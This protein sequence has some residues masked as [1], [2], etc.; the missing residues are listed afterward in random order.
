MAETSSTLPV[1]SMLDLMREKKT[2]QKVLVEFS[3]RHL[4][5]D[6]KTLAFSIRAGVVEKTLQ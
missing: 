2:G 3:S 1:L 6:A 5:P 4:F